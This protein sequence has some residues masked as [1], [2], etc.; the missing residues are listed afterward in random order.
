MWIPINKQEVHEFIQLPKLIVSSKDLDC[1][2]KNI[3]FEARGEPFLGKVA[4]AQVT[5]NRTYHPYRFPSTICKTVYARKQFSWTS[6]GLKVKDAKLWEESKL[7]ASATIEGKAYIPNFDALY[8]HA[9]YVKPKWNKN[10]EVIAVIGS[11]IFYN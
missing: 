7:I 9:N 2:A 5:I 11:H 8:F 4:V 6:M 3:Y 10:K 1:L